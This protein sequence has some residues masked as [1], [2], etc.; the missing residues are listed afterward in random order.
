MAEIIEL[1]KSLKDMGRVVIM[2]PVKDGQHISINIDCPTVIKE[3]LGNQQ[4]LP[5][6]REVLPDRNVDTVEDLA[7]VD[8]LLYEKLMSDQ[9]Q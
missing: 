3:H 8:P 2:L 6:E 4:L 5:N 1:V 7:L 9:E